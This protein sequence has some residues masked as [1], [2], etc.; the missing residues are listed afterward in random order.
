MYGIFYING[1]KM[2]L[3]RV[4]FDR[5]IAEKVTDFYNET[6]WDEGYYFEEELYGPL[7]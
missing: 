5:G 6:N 2:E 3:I 4:C 1:N 7:Q